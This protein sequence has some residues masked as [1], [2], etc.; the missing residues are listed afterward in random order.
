MWVELT[1]VDRPRHAWGTW[2][3]SAQEVLPDSR[4][5]LKRS[6]MSS[7]PPFPQDCSLEW[8][9]GYVLRTFASPELGYIHRIELIPYRSFGF[10]ALI[11]ERF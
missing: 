4:L 10:R 3:T 8:Q 5:R 1:L 6:D 11:L 2:P 9:R 7:L